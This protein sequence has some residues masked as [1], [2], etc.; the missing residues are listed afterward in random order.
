V[1]DGF[2]HLTGETILGYHVAVAAA[3]ALAR[4]AVEPA[5]E[6]AFLATFL[7]RW[8]EALEGDRG[9]RRGKR[10]SRRIGRESPNVRQGGVTSP[11]KDPS[12]RL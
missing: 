5:D 6:H 1:P 12:C 4:V 7:A 3:L 10:P 2:F 8:G 9:Q 11:G